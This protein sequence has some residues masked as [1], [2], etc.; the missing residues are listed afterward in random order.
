MKYSIGMEN[1]VLVRE[2]RK[3]TRRALF[4]SSSLAGTMPRIFFWLGQ[5]SPHTFISMNVPSQAPTPIG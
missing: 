1:I 2:A 3:A 5:I 4:F